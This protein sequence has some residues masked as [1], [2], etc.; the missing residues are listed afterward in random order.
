MVGGLRLGVGY[1][2]SPEPGFFPFVAGC[3]IAALALAQLSIRAADDSE[4][5]PYKWPR[6]VGLGLALLAYTL[7][8]EA[9]GFVV[10]TSLLAVAVMRLS[11]P[12]PWL[13]TI[14]ISVSVAAVSYVLFCLILHVDLPT[15]TLLQLLWG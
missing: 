14:L 2:F 7:V 1:L 6:A 13:K 15:G 11:H 8:L 4:G 12:Q 10:A 9:V 3:G 5:S